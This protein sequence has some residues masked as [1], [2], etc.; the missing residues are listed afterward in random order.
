VLLVVKDEV[1]D[2]VGNEVGGE[3]GDKVRDKVGDK[4][5]DEVVFVVVGDEVVKCLFSLVTRVQ[6]ACCR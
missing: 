2:E 5:G 1:G 4:V 6:S 3:V